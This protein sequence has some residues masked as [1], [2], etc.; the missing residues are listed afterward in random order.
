[1]KITITA[2][3]S[4]LVKLTKDL[5][6]LLK[7]D[8][9]RFTVK[10]VPQIQSPSHLKP[11]PKL[12]EIMERALA[13]A[14]QD[15]YSANPKGKPFQHRI[16]SATI[17]A[18]GELRRALSQGSLALTRQEAILAFAKDRR[19]IRGTI[20]DAWLKRVMDQIFKR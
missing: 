19:L 5:E 14:H 16:K 1:M 13:V 8:G 11:I 17:V 20:G 7:L 4:G 6:R 12:S 2:N 18:R 10:L 3:S 9:K 15:L